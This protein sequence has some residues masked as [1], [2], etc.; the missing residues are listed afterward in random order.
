MPALINNVLGMKIYIVQNI[1]NVNSVVFSKKEGK[2][3]KE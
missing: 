3:K 2:K 1:Q